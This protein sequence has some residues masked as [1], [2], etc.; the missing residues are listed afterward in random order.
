MDPYDH[1]SLFIELPDESPSPPP[2]PRED[3]FKKP[4]PKQFSKYMAA[5][6]EATRI[7]HLSIMQ[8]NGWHNQRRKMLTSSKHTH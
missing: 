2:A 8:G 5:K 7:K 1:D 4:F 6:R 3:I